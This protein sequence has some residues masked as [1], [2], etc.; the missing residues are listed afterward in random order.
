[1]VP[2]HRPTRHPCVARRGSS[3]RP[4][5]RFVGGPPTTEA[6]QRERSAPVALSRA[7]RA[8][9]PQCPSSAVVRIASRTAAYC[10]PVPRRDVVDGGGQMFGRT[11]PGRG[12]CGDGVP[13]C[14][15][16]AEVAAC[17]I[18]P[19]AV[20]STANRGAPSR[21][22]PPRW[23]PRR[24]EPGSADVP[25]DPSAADRLSAIRAAPAGYPGSRQ[26]AEAPT[27][28]SNEVIGV[29]HG[30]GPPWRATA[31]IQVGHCR[32]VA[33]RTASQ[34]AGGRG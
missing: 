27:A 7:T 6:T 33:G 16:R 10:G 29:V 26:R 4:F 13:S 32:G 3:R 19:Q 24:W 25:L 21:R 5:D 17:V 15:A 9:C 1:M 22:A 11:R 14:R 34:A 23:C 2:A 20:G 12:R 18:P 8:T 30:T 31:V 28:R